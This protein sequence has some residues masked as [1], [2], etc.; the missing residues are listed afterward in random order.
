MGRVTRGST[1]RARAKRVTI[2]SDEEAESDESDIAADGPANKFSIQDLGEPETSGD[3]VTVSSPTVKSRR[4][5]RKSQAAKDTFINDDSEESDD[6]PRRRVSRVRL[7]TPESITGSAEDDHEE[8]PPTVS[9]REREDLKEDLDF[10][11]S[12]PPTSVRKSQSTK[13]SA[14]QMA[15]ELLKRRRAGDR[16]DPVGENENSSQG[17]EENGAASPDAVDEEVNEDISEDEEDEPPTASYRDMFRAGEEDEDFIVDDPEGDE[18]V[19]LANMQVPLHLTAH[20]RMKPRELF[21]Y[22]VEWMIQKKINPTFQ[23]DDEIY[24]LAFLKLDD[25]V[26]GLSSSKFESSV[27]RKDFRFALRARPRLI[28][29]NLSAGDRIVLGMPGCDACGRQSHPATFQVSFEGKPYQKETLENVSDDDDSDIEGPDD[30]D[31]DAQGHQIAK[32]GKSWNLGIHCKNNA[33]IAHTLHHWR[34]HLYEWI[35]DYL[36]AEDHLSKDKL[37]E[38]ESWSRKKKRKYAN[39]IVDAMAADGEIDSLYKDFK[40]NLEAARN[41]K[42][43]FKF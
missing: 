25:E 16:S 19:V 23:M 40:N 18:T 35:V 37:F 30:L 12:S 38:R 24:R 32:E 41:A 22:V 17:S 2:I 21:K 4:V 29:V 26:Q 7:K 15:L 6:T 33:E 14:R 10:L 9:K 8:A 42:V 36:I 43:S 39:N 20:G 28:A 5:P 13:Q 34:Y 11:Q 27:W 31:Y 3:E 1:Q